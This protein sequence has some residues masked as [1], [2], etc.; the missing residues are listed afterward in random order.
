MITVF[1]RTFL[2]YFLLLVFMKI[3]GKRQ[4]GE[5][6]ISELVS[7]L[8]I[9]EIAA[10]PIE[11]FNIPLTGVAIPLILIIS[12]EII[13]SFTATKCEWFKRFISG[14]PSILINRG[15]LDISE[16][17]KTRLSVEELVSELRLKGVGTIEEVEYAILE[18][19]G[20]ISVILKKASSPVTAKDLKLHAEDD[21]I[22]HLIIV[23]GHIKEAELIASSKDT[24]WLDSELKRTG[25]SVNDIFLM[26]VNDSG[27]TY[28]IYK[29]DRK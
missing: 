8:L 19:N 9:S 5:L 28:I 18:Q 2:I 23:D 27:K 22:S 21:G 13:L 1:V 4:V 16:L 29:K 3:M 25:K 24:E 10:I 14:K 20:Q 15:T 26:S 6:E 11:D 7:T 17:S 12:L